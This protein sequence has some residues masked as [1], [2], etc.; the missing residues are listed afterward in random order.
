M[1]ACNLLLDESWLT[2]RLASPGERATGAAR[3]EGPVRHQT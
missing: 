3:V 2:G 1:N